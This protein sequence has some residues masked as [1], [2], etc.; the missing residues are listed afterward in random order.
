M[1]IKD[2]ILWNTHAI[3]QANSVLLIFVFRIELNLNNL[4]LHVFFVYVAKQKQTKRK[5]E[6]QSI[7]IDIPK[8]ENRYVF[9][10][11]E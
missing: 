5:T 6:K 4:G 3:H 1:E 2:N 9:T 7:Y 11:T 8:N 10:M